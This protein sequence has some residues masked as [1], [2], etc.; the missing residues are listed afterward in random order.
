MKKQ[1]CLLIVLLLL[2]QQLQAN[3]KLPAIIADNMVLQQQTSVA[4]WG[5]AD[6]NEQIEVTAGWNNQTVKTVADAK[7]NWLVRMNTI[8]A[9]GPYTLEFKGHNSIRVNNI[10]LGEV[11]LC[12]GQ[13]NMEFPLAKGQGWRTGIFDYEKETAAANYPNMRLFTVKQAVAGEPLKNVEGSWGSCT[14]ETAAGFSA[15]A[16]FFARKLM[17]ETGIPVG[18]IHTSWGGTPAESWVSKEVLESNGILQPILTRY[19]KAVIDYPEVQ[20]KYET[21][22]D[23]WKKAPR[24]ESK[25]EPKKPVDPLKDSKSPTKLYNAMIHP[26]VPYTLKG[27]IWYQGESNSPRAYQY[28]TLFPALINSWRKEWQTSFPFYFVQIATHYKQHPEVREAQLMTYR[29]VPNTGMVVITDLGDS[30][31]VHPR[32]K[33]PVGERL[34]RWALAKQY[35]RKD[36]VYSGPLYKSSEQKGNKIILSFEYAD[37]L[38]SPEALLNEFV[39]AGADKKFVKANA[40]IV[41]NIIEVWSDEVAKPT[42]VRFAWKPFSRPAL[43]NKAGLPASPF[44]TDDWPVET[45]GKY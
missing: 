19:D 14:P 12:S 5:W 21:D 34:A 1:A 23:A 30:T 41:G 37:G 43:F 29:S 9:G 3:M 17:Q 13:S 16:Y 33:L 28:R 4:L 39:I 25:P 2:L 27:V 38:N 18:M 22:L 7:G 10:L 24:D 32:N 20:K 15:V 36:M 45:E 8:K 40:K 31:D 26:L 42:A 11:W 6:P 35:G 44:R